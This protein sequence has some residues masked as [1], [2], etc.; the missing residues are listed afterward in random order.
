MILD[1]SV[2]SYTYSY[3]WLIICKLFKSKKFQ[4]IWLS[5]LRKNRKKCSI[6]ICTFIRMYKSVIW[7]H[8]YPRVPI[9]PRQHWEINC[10]SELDELLHRCNTD[11][12][13]T[14]S[15]DAVGQ[16]A[17]WNDLPNYWCYYPKRRGDSTVQSCLSITINTCPKLWISCGAFPGGQKHLQSCYQSSKE[18]EAAGV[19]SAGGDNI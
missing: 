13:D 8:R 11:T 1:N 16:S 18:S 2:C 14:S 3:V 10:Q 5:I 15:D 4:Q 6:Y 9:H 7:Y 17:W 19:S 12:V